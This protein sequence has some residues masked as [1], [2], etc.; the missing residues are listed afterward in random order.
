[1]PSMKCQPSYFSRIESIKLLWYEGTNQSI[2]YMVCCRQKYTIKAFHDQNRER[3]MP[4]YIWMSLE[5]IT[6]AFI[7]RFTHRP[8]DK[9][10]SD[11]TTALRQRK[12]QSV[13]KPLIQLATREDATFFKIV[14]FSQWR[15]QTQFWRLHDTTKSCIVVKTQWLKMANLKVIS[16]SDT[17]TETFAS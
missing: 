3:F 6:R 7:R 9:D 15:P 2:H 11:A 14:V 13:D 8:P 17:L 4:G 12:S 5:S 16:S 1:M 10:Q